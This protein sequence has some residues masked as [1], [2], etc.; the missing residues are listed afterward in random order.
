[1]LEYS[2]VARKRNQNGNLKCNLTMV[3]QKIYII[4]TEGNQIHRYGF[5]VCLA[6]S[7]SQIMFRTFTVATIQGG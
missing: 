5:R 1:M 2:D 7:C 6:S 4:S 3:E